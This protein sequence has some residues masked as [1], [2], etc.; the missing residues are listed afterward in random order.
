MSGET[1][2]PVAPA[3]VAL[4]S[5]WKIACLCSLSSLSSSTQIPTVDMLQHPLATR[6]S[7]ARSGHSVSHDANKEQKS[8]TQTYRSDEAKFYVTHV[9]DMDLCR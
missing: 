7:V 5:T 9:A 6:A 1:S 2:R 4:L 8:K 3:R